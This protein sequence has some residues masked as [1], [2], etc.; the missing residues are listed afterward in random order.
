[1]FPVAVFSVVKS[2]VVVVE[3]MDA[4]RHC[5]VLWPYWI[6]LIWHHGREIHHFQAQYL[7]KSE[8]FG[9]ANFASRLAGQMPGWPAWGESWAR[10]RGG[11]EGS[12]EKDSGEVPLDSG[13]LWHPWRASVSME[14]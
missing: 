1:M 4:T 5:Q 11:C 9:I 6:G 10:Q 7:R 2:L 14:N 3:V 13:A 12:H 8:Y